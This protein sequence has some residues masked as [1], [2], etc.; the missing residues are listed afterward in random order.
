M[1]TFAF[2]WED[3][4]ECRRAEHP[5]KIPVLVPFIGIVWS[6]AVDFFPDFPD[7]YGLQTYVETTLRPICAACPVI[8]ECAAHAIPHEKHG[9]WAGMTE[10]ARRTYRKEHHITYSPTATPLLTIVASRDL[11]EAT[12]TAITEAMKES[13]SG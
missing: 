6:P 13:T 3:D 11:P 4:A 1:T 5:A 8:D 7:R 12:R 10:R 9:F 2:D